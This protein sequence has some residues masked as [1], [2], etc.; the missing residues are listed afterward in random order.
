MLAAY[1]N[2]QF[3]HTI[4]PAKLYKTDSFPDL[5]Y[6]APALIHAFYASIPDLH[7]VYDPA[8]L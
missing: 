3:I 5:R 7:P 4:P 2:D 1:L 6:T 8:P